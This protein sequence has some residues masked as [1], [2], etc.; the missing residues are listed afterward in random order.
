MQTKASTSKKCGRRTGYKAPATIKKMA[1]KTLEQIMQ[2]ESASP[3]ARAMAACKLI[4]E[5]EVKA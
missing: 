1:I 4:D 3:D 2:D 5:I